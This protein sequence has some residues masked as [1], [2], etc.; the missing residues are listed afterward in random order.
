MTQVL[1]AF[2]LVTCA[3]EAIIIYFGWQLSKFAEG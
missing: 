2:C 1:V 3:A